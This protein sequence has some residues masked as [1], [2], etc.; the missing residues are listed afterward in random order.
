M[1]SENINSV[2]TKIEKSAKGMQITATFFF[3]LSLVVL[4]GSGYLFHISKMPALSESTVAF[5]IEVAFSLFTRLAILVVAFYLVRLLMSV[6]TYNL[7]LSNDL[8]SQA[9]IL[10]LYNP[11]GGLSHNELYEIFN[12]N[13]HRFEASKGFSGGDEIDKLVKLAKAIDLGPNKGQ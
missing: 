5:G 2:I 11:D 9:H 8:S 10:E 6:V 7:E 12:T 3:I 4:V 1:K 13:R